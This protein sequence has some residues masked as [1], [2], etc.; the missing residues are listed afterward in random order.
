M[1]PNR[2][3]CKRCV[4]F[5]ELESGLLSPNQ[6]TRPFNLGPAIQPNRQTLKQ[7]LISVAQTI[8]GATML[9]PVGKFN[10]VFLHMKRPQIDC[11]LFTSARDLLVKC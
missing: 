6:W 2:L 7:D 5:L 1:N 9:N 11:S 3:Q 10:V 8:K 4:L